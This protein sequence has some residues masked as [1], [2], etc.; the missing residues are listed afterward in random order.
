MMVPMFLRSSGFSITAIRFLQ[1][2]SLTLSALARSV[3][4]DLFFSSIPDESFSA[5]HRKPRTLRIHQPAH[6][7]DH[8]L[9]IR[10]IQ[11]V[12]DPAGEFRAVGFLVAA[13]GDRRRADTQ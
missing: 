2:K 12:A 8:L 4:L 10:R 7:L 9:V 6:A 11:H 5:I 13:R 3:G 1:R